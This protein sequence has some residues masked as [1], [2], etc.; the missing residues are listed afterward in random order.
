MRNAQRFGTFLGS[1]LGRYGQSVLLVLIASAIGF[2]I[3]FVIEAVNLVMLYLA[4]VVIAAVFLGRG[5][6]ILASVLSVITFD[7]F[8]VEPRL[9]LSVADTQ[10]ILTFFGL[11]AVGMVISITVAQLRNQVEIIRQ[12]EAHTAALNSLI[13]DLTG[14]IQLEDM[15][16]SVVRHIHQAF[17]QRVVVLLPVENGLKLTADSAQINRLENAEYQMRP[18]SL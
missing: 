1:P 2:P 8:L 5:P 7:F 16:N 18:T 10:Y 6:A 17:N 15:L 13:Q 9:S 11:L 14:A 12:R 4:A 3:Y